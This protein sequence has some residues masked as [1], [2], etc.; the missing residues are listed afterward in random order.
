MAALDLS[1]C[2]VDSKR[3]HLV[4]DDSK[5][6]AIWKQLPNSR[7]VSDSDSYL[8]V[9]SAWVARNPACGGVSTTITSRYCVPEKNQMPAK[10]CS[11]RNR[12]PNIEGIC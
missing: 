2:I 11:S 9:L 8:G 12:I 4:A 5:L 7:L 6:S 10:H 1:S 3:E